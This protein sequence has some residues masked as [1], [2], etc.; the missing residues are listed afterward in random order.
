MP[1]IL[2][3][4]VKA[5]M[6]QGAGDMKEGEVF[7]DNA[8]H[9]KAFNGKNVNIVP[10]PKGALL[11]VDGVSMSMTQRE[12][13]KFMALDDFHRRRF[14]EQLVYDNNP[15][16][17]KKLLGESIPDRILRA[18]IGTPYNADGEAVISNDRPQAQDFLRDK[19][20]IMFDQLE[21]MNHGQEESQ[22]V[23]I[24]R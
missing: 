13:D 17:A 4:A 1:N 9:M 22:S 2:Q 10:S 3:A 8:V 16:L 18:K 14:A 12:Y 21:N 5:F 15:R 6:K 19:V 7:N 11:Q 23:G 24:K 20:S